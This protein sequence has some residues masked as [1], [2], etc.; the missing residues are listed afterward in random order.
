VFS[1]ENSV[2]SLGDFVFPPENFLCFGLR[3][4]LDP[5]NF[6]NP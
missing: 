5:R 2:F 3:A 4:K 1:L 6:F